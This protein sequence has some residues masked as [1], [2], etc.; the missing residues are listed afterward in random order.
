MQARLARWNPSPRLSTTPLPQL[1][2]RLQTSDSSACARDPDRSPEIERLASELNAAGGMAA[3]FGQD[4][5]AM[6][7]GDA[8]RAIVALARQAGARGETFDWPNITIDYGQRPNAVLN[9]ER[10]IKGGT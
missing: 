8:A 2:P 9:W 1:T 5:S 4:F 10:R 7:P 3:I 6:R